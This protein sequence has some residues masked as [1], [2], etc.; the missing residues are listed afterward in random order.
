VKA[1]DRLGQWTLVERIDTGGNATVW[2]GVDETGT[3]VAVKVLKAKRGEAFSRFRD[4]ISA[5]Q[6]LGE[7]SGVL[8]VLATHLPHDPTDADPAW[9]AMPIA[10]PVRTVLK[11]APLEAVVEAVA[12]FAETL[13][14]LADRGMAHRDIKPANLYRWNGRWVIGDFGLVEFPD[15]EA[16]TRKGQKLGPMHFVAPEMITNPES[17][18]GPPAD[19]YSLAKTLWVLATDQTWPPQGEYRLD[20]PDLLL[21]SLIVHRRAQLIDPVIARATQYRPADRLTAKRF[22]QHLRAWLA[23][24]SVRRSDAGEVT[25]LLESLA[26]YDAVAVARQK[27]LLAL[28][29]EWLKTWAEFTKLIEPVWTTLSRLPNGLSNTSGIEIFMSFALLRGVTDYQSSVGRILF[30]NDRPDLGAMQFYFGIAGGYREAREFSLAAAYMAM[31]NRDRHLLWSNEQVADLGTAEFSQAMRSLA[32]DL[33]ENL[34]PTLAH[35]TAI[36]A[37]RLARP[38]A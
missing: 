30:D 32:D 34:E 5:L 17:A 1:G 12:T 37:D 35:L 25:D 28:R 36:L 21:S 23:P 29:N 6:Q 15:K 24:E 38:K 9:L 27:S 4:E 26:A 19:V 14:D 10:E 7:H 2:R 11:D 18:E 33:Q 8:P 22:G 3:A 13:A 16:L 20:F 31:D